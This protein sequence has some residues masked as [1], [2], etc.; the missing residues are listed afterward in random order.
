MIAAPFINFIAYIF[1]AYA[2]GPM[3]TLVVF[4]F[5]VVLIILQNATGNW[6]KSIKMKEAALNDD[7]LKIV[8]DLVIGCRTIKC[9]GWEKHYEKK[10]KNIR[11]AHIKHVAKFNI[12]STLGNTV[13][14]NVGLLA[15]YC[16]IVHQWQKGKELKMADVMSLLS[17]IYL[18]FFSVNIQAYFGMINFKSYLAVLERLSTVFSMEEYESSRDTD[19]KPEDV[20]IEV[21]NGGF[22]W[23]FRVKENQAGTTTGK[24]AI[25]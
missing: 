24:I 25:E 2:V 7:R 6:A 19:V 12:V 17:M 14:Q 22:S 23:G 15:V 21:K 9:Y 4:L 1:I 3:Y 10:A 18:I 5:W 16:I 13:F 20:S 11:D 8:N